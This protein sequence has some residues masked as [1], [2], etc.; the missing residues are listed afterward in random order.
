MDLS[1]ISARQIMTRQLATACPNVHVLNAVDRLIEWQV[2]GLPVITDKG[3][4]IG[5]F[6]EQSAIAALDLADTTHSTSGL[7][8]RNCLNLLIAADM[9][10]P[11]SLVLD[12]DADVLTCTDRL[13]SHRVSG[14]PV[15]A[16]NGTVIGVFSEKS[17]MQ[18]F[19]G[20]CWEQSPSSSV[21]AWMDTEDGR[22][23]HEQTT[24]PEILERFHQTSFRRLMVVRQ[25]RLVGEITRRDA[26]AA[27]VMTL[28][29]TLKDSQKIRGESGLAYKATV[30]FWMHH[31]VPAVSPCRDV[32]S[33]AQMF[34]ESSIRQIPVVED[35]KLCGQI[36][37]S[38]LLRAVQRHFPEPRPAVAKPQPLYLSALS[39]G[40]EFVAS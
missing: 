28:R 38:D 3:Q 19:I 34:I 13:I 15:L 39:P 4:L 24:L 1:P 35:E 40:R 23:I 5:R 29:T 33:I 16:A 27:A 25:G 18:V 17:A 20:L 21:T 10:K 8:M 7:N 26:L 2:S 9:M 6:S 37:R 11:P 14:A 30:S 32:L 12:A 31:E 36:S 22:L